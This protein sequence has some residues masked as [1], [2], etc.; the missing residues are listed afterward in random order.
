M[1]GR[2]SYLI[3]GAFVSIGL[4]SLLF[5]ILS[6]AGEGS[7]QENQ[8]YTILFDRDISGLTLGAPVRYLGVGV[9]QV[10]DLRLTDTADTAVRVDIAVLESTPISDATYA[11]LAFQGVT[12]VAF[13][14]LAADEHVASHRS[15]SMNSEYPI[16]PT[17]NVG[18]A[19]VLSEAPEISHRIV[20]ILDRVARLLDDD[21]IDALAGLLANIETI[22]HLL[23]GNDERL[24][25]LPQRLD[26]ALAQIET[27]FA[28]VQDTMDQVEPDLLATLEQLNATSANLADITTRLDGWLADN[29]RDM[30]SFFGAGLG[31]AAELIADTRNAIR[32][33]EKLLA[34]LRDSPSQIVYK[35][36]RDPVVAE[37]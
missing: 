3:V 4:V 30:D 21:N 19:A 23:A 32:E 11:S 1:N 2:N 6:L 31:Q 18:L 10:V 9:G 16:I 7:T 26:A 22:T 8:R 25:S 13:I 15:V 14:S 33:L 35:P 37:P 34:E 28:R 20:R 24:A 17:R 29:D 27:T 5:V 12:G 36:Q